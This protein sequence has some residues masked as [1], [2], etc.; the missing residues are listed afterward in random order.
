[1]GG[2]TCNAEGDRPACSNALKEGLQ[3]Y[4]WSLLNRDYNPDVLKKWVDEGCMETVEKRLG[5]RF[6]LVSTRATPTVRQGGLL[7]FRMLVR[8]TG[9]AGTIN[10]RPV[11]LVLLRHDAP[12]RRY[13]IQL[14]TTADWKAHQ[15]RIRACKLPIPPA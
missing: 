11:I 6:R 1:M 15:K 5:Y 9:W 10:R 14:G 7:R 8:N 2:E 3:R 12:H 4:H 13:R